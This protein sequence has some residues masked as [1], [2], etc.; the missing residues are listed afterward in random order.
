MFIFGKINTR[1]ISLNPVFTKE[2][3]KK[4]IKKKYAIKAMYIIVKIIK[5]CQFFYV[6]IVFNVPPSL[7]I[8]TFWR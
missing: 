3:N 2:T 6:L 8:D 7:V 4:I 1:K 5:N